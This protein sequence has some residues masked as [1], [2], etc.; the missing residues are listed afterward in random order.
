MASIFSMEI[1]MTPAPSLKNVSIAQLQ[2]AIAKALGDL[3]GHENC[4]VRIDA[5]EFPPVDSFT[6]SNLVREKSTLRLE[7]EV[8]NKPDFNKDQ[9]I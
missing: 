4:S 7:V 8:K 5:V 1:V 9:F 2:D 6:L 3:T